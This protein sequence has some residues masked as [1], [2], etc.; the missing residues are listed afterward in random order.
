MKK[1]FYVLMVILA[2]SCKNEEARNFPNKAAFA[3]PD[4]ASIFSGAVT[5]W[6]NLNLKTATCTLTMEE[7]WQDDSVRQEPY[8]LPENFIKLYTPLLRWSPDSSQILD[9]GS[10]EAKLKNDKTGL[11]IEEAGPDTEVAVLY[12]HQNQRTR[13]L[14]VGPSATIVDGKWLNNTE[15]MVLGTFTSDEGITDTLA[16][17]IDLQEK[18]FT[19]YNVK[20]KPG[21]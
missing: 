1:V 3:T 11:V 17:K 19:L 6:I 15:L 4:S 13:L 8:S 21:K 2:A 7:R 14:N 20:A 16:W 5:T 18:L 12:P 9:L 10:Y